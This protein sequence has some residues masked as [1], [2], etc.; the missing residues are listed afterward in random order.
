MA[1]KRKAAAGRK[2]KA[3][4]IDDPAM[5][6]LQGVEAVAARP[7][8]PSTTAR[9]KAWQREKAEWQAR[10]REAAKLIAARHAAMMARRP[11]ILQR[12]YGLPR[13]IERFLRSL[14]N[15][16]DRSFW[17]FEHGYLDDI[18]RDNGQQYAFLCAYMQ[19]CAQGYIEGRIADLEPKRERS[20]KAN[21]AKRQRPQDCGGHMMTL[22]QRDAAIVAE[23]PTL[24][25][26][27]GS[28]EAQLRLAEKYGLSSREQVANIVRKAKRSG[29]A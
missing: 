14:F 26:M 23:Y 11:A 13:D 2:R 18:A 22:D 7:G 29:T 24:R 8:K 15:A 3:D 5:P 16:S 12:P 1:K 21:A 27:L 28:I 4:I 6:L 10:E 19:G 17:Y 20:R 9:H 25:A